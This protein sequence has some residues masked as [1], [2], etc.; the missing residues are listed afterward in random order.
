MFGLP[1]CFADTCIVLLVV[2]H[3]ADH[4]L[5][6]GHGLARPGATQI[7]VATRI[8]FFVDFVDCDH[9]GVDYDLGDFVDLDGIT[10]QECSVLLIFGISTTTTQSI[11]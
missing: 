8:D 6:R 4:A 10:R 5:A 7:T 3:T 9:L 11:R 2:Q 1:Y